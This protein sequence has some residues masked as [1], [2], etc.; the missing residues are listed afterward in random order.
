MAE[1]YEEAMSIVNQQY[2]MIGQHHIGVSKGTGPYY[3][4]FY[5]PWESGKPDAPHPVPGTPHILLH[6]KGIAFQGQDLQNLLAGESL[7]HLGSVNPTTNQPV[8]PLWYKWKQYFSTF[9]TLEQT[10]ADRQ[11]YL[12]EVKNN[13]ETRSFDQWYDQSREEVWLRHG[14]FPLASEATDKTDWFSLKQKQL[15]QYMKSYLQTGR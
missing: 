13:G 9:A 6:E 15:L 1:P 3:S 14:L 2:P 8:D 7:H 12:D 11:A 4:E 10:R 5:S